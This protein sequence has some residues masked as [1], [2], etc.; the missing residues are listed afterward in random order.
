MAASFP[1]DVNWT[2][3]KHLK[4]EV[5]YEIKNAKMNYCSTFFKE[6]FGKMKNTWRGISRLIGNESKSTKITQLET[7][8]YIS[9][10]P[11]PWT[12]PLD[13]VHGL[14]KWTTHGLP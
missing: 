9:L 14:L 7:V 13:L 8:W 3:Y 6:T 4:N 2:S 12:T 11:S 5:N 10:T 1:T